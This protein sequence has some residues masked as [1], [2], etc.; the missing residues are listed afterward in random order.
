V[1]RFHRWN[2]IPE[3]YGMLPFKTS[4]ISRLRDVPTTS[5]QPMST[6]PPFYK[7]IQNEYF[8]ESCS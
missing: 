3:A 4:S 2:D 5:F 1:R 7:K 8:L 6:I